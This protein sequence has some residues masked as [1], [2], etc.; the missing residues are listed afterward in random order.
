MIKKIDKLLLLN[1]FK[2]FAVI[3][4]IVV[5]IMYTQNAV[6]WVGDIA[7][8]S[9]GFITYAKLITYLV[10]MTA[11][12]VG[13]PITTVIAA[14]INMKELVETQE[15]VA[16][17]SAGVSEKRIMAP[18]IIFTVALIPLMYLGNAFMTPSANRNLFDL[19]HNIKKSN[20]IL[21]MKAGVFYNDL[22]GYSIKINKKS[23]NERAVED[24]IIYDHT[25]KKGNVLV[26]MA[27][28]GEIYSAQGDKFLVLKL[29]KGHSY[30]EKSKIDDSE[31]EK[32]KNKFIRS[33]FKE[34]K[35]VINMDEIG[36]VSK[37][38]FKSKVYSKSAI[39]IE[40]DIRSMRKSILNI[41][42]NDMK[43]IFDFV[44]SLQLVIS[45]IDASTVSSYPVSS[46]P[47]LY[48]LLNHY[49]KDRGKEIINLTAK[50]ISDHKKNLEVNIPR[51]I[52]LERKI[53]RFR[54]QHLSYILQAIVVLLMLILGSSLGLMSRKGDIKLQSMIFVSL[55]LI[56]YFLVYK[57]LDLAEEGIMEPLVAIMIPFVFVFT[58]TIFFMRKAL[59]GE[60][61][62]FDDLKYYMKKRYRMLFSSKM[63]NKKKTLK[64]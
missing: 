30:I 43:E 16:M 18:L 10:T 61:I 60:T 42:N 4:A 29:F 20:P 48:Q 24:I 50:K 44:K 31:K 56:Y 34:Q 27:K 64:R 59:R 7:G 41:K 63:K 25:Q 36:N 55:F 5:F 45:D 11:T 6:Q 40:K 35:I 19:I 26:T 2:A 12:L 37:K 13:Y 15:I 39:M 1:F 8:K 22:E 54:V 17:R 49:E 14:V 32:E 46:K 3:F 28:Y 57:G 21:D 52:K 51:I 38:I 53:R 62:R 23:S 47:I 33:T 58:L 9:L